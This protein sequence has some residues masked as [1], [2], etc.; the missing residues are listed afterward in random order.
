M[1]TIIQGIINHPS[2]TDLTKYLKFLCLEL[3]ACTLS[4]AQKIKDIPFDT[5]GNFKIELEEGDIA[6]QYLVKLVYKAGNKKELI[7]ASA[8]LFAG[9]THDLSFYFDPK[10]YEILL[11]YLQAQVQPHLG[12]L[13]IINL[14]E[15]QLQQLSSLSK[16]DITDLRALQLAMVWHEEWKV[17]V[18]KYLIIY[19]GKKDADKDYFQKAF[20]KLENLLDEFKTCQSILFALAK[21]GV[22]HWKQGISLS[23]NQLAEKIENVLAKKWVAIPISSQRV[24][25][26]GLGYLR[27]AIL[28][29]AAYDDLY[30]DAKLIYLSSY[31]AQTKSNLLNLS[32]EQNGLSNL[33]NSESNSNET[34][35]KELKKNAQDF[36]KKYSVKFDITDLKHVVDWDNRIRNFTP[37]LALIIP[38]LREN[39]WDKTTLLKY[40]QDHWAALIQ[41]VPSSIK[42]PTE[43]DDNKEPIRSYAYDLF[44]TLT[45]LFPT[46]KLVTQLNQSNL[47]NKDDFYRILRR[48]PNFDIQNQAVSR[49]FSIKANDRS[50]EKVSEKDYKNLQELQRTIKLADGVENLHIVEAL[51]KENLSSGMKISRFGKFE[52]TKVM[53]EYHFHEWEIRGVWCRA[54]AFYDTAKEFVRQYLQYD[55]VGS[56]MPAILQNNIN[57]QEALSGLPDMETLFGSLDKCSCKHC[58]SVYSPA[59][60]LTDMLQWLKSDISCQQSSISGFTELDRRRPDIKYIQL[61]CKNSNTVLPYIDLVNEVLLSHL[62]SIPDATLLKDLQTTWETDRLLMEPEHINHI[63]FNNAKAKLKNTLCP[64][65]LP[66]DINWTESRSYLNELGTSQAELIKIFSTNQ[67]ANHH[68][69]AWSKAFL[70]IDTTTYEF[71][72]QVSPTTNFWE[73]HFNKNN[74]EKNLDYFLRF[75]EIEKEDFQQIYETKFVSNKTTLLPLDVDFEGCDWDE[76][77]I[78]STWEDDDALVHRFVRFLRLRNL[79]GLTTEQLDRAIYTYN[80]TDIN[81]A[82]LINLTSIIDLSQKY[83]LNLDE[84]LVWFS[85][86][87]F[88][89]TS[90]FDWSTYY[91]NVY[92]KPSFSANRIA[93]FDPVFLNSSANTTTVKALSNEQK[94]W[95]NQSLG[96]QDGDIYLLNTY[97]Y[98]AGDPKLKTTE[99]QFYHI[100]ASLAKTLKLSIQELLASFKLF[101]SPFDGFPNAPAEV[102]YY[103]SQLNDT[104]NIGLSIEKL[105]DSYTGTAFFELQNDKATNVIFEEICKTVWENLASKISAIYTEHSK[106]YDTLANDFATLPTYVGNVPNLKDEL[107]QLLAHELEIEYKL[108]EDI[109]DYEDNKW[110]VSCL[111]NSIAKTDWISG[112]DIVF[113]PIFRYLYRIGLYTK[114]FE[115]GDNGLHALFDSYANNSYSLPVTDALFWLGNDFSTHNFFH[116]LWLKKLTA[117]KNT[118]SID[119]QSLF[120]QI[121]ALN[122]LTGIPSAAN[123]NIILDTCY[124][125]LSLL[126]NLEVT[127]QQFK[128][129]YLRAQCLAINPKDL[130]ETLTSTFKLLKFEN[131]IAIS[132]PTIWSWVWDDFKVSGNN[133]ITIGDEKAEIYTLL[134]SKYTD[135]QWPKIITPIHNKF[136]TKLRDALVAY[137]IHNKSYDNENDIYGHFL[138][139]P[140]ME[141]CMKTSRI[142]LAISGVQLLIHKALMGL[143]PEVCPNEDNKQE[144]KWRKNYRVWEANRKV[145]LYPENWIEPE[146]RLDKSEFFEELEDLLLQNEIN[147]EN[148]EKAMQRY[149]TN[150]NKVA[151][152]DIRGT[153]L[154]VDYN[155]DPDPG[156]LHVV[157]RTFSTPHE[158]YYRKRDSD[159]Y[160]TAWEKLEIDID[161]DHIIL[162]FHNRKLHL[163]WPM[164]IEKEHRKIKI[165]EDNAPYFEIRMCYSKLEFGKW[166]S[167]RILEGHVLAGHLAGKGCFN[168]LRYKLGQD[169]GS[170][171]IHNGSLVWGN[172]TFFDYAPVSMNKNKFFFWAE[173]RKDSGE[174]IIHIR[175][176]FDDRFDDYHDGYTELAY[177]DSFKISACDDRLEIIPPVIEEVIFDDLTNGKRFLARPYNTLPDGQLMIE[178]KDNEEDMYPVGGLYVKKEITHSHGSI[179]ILHKTN[180]IY[181]LTY[182]HQFK[183]ATFEMPFFLK[184][185]IHTLF[186]EKRIEQKCVKIPVFSNGATTWYT[187]EQ[188]NVLSKYYVQP[189]EHPYAC[190]MLGE[191]NQYGIKGLLSSRNPNNQ[192]RRQ[193]QHNNYFIHQYLPIL[194]Q[195]NYPFPIDEFDFSYFGAYQKY[196]WEIFFHAPSLI[197]KQLKNNGQF[198][199]AIKWLQFIFDPTNRD[200]ALNDKRFWM[201]KPFLKD[202]SENSIQNLMHLLGATGLNPEQ[203]KKREAL[204]AQIKRWKDNPFEPHKI[205]E[206]RHRAYMLWTVCEYIDVLIE[207]G[208]SLF[209]QDS[210]E[211][212]NEATNLYILAG[213]LLGNRPKTLNKP[214]NVIVDSFDTIKDG[215]DD[216]SNAVL[217][218]ENEIPAYSPIICC[219]ET[220]NERYQLPDLLFCIPDNPKLQELWNRAEDRLFKIRHCMNIEG[221]IRELPLFQPPIDPALLVRATAMG[222]DIG[223][224]LQEL[225]APT[226]HYRYTY[227]LQKANEFTGEVKALGG[228]LLS[229]LEKKDTEELN[230]LRQLHEQNILKATRNLKKMAIEEAKLGLAS[231]QHSKKLIEIRL[232]EYEGKDTLSD[233]ESRSMS[234]TK[235]AEL[236]MY[237]EQAQVLIAAAL[238]PIPNQYITAG[239]PPSVTIEPPTS[240]AKLEKISSLVGLSFGIVGSIYRNISSMQ[241][242]KAGYKRRQE[243]WDFQ[244]TTAKEEL[245]Q[246]EKSILS[247]EIRIAIAEKDFENHELQIEQSKEVFDFVKNKFTNLNLYSW[248]SGELMKLHYRAYKLAYEMAKQAQRAMNKELSIDLSIIDFGHWNSSRKGLLAGE[249]LSMQLKELDNAYIKND[250]RRFELSKDISLKLL[251][252][253]ALVHL[254]QHKYCKV[255]LEEE[256]LNLVFKS[257]NLTGMQIKSIGI[258]IPCVTGSQISTNVKLRVQN[259]EELITSSGV[260]DLGV[261][262]PNF[263]QA[264]YM[265]FEYLELKEDQAD[266]PK[267]FINLEVM[268]EGD[269]DKNPPE[270]D[271][272]TISDVVLH[273][274]YYAENNSKSTDT[275]GE[276]NVP[277]NQQHLVMSWKYDFPLE[278][279][280]IN[281]NIPIIDIKSFAENPLNKSKVPYKLRPLSFNLTDSFSYLIKDTND[282]MNLKSGTF[283]TDGS[284][285]D[286][287]NN[288]LSIEN[289][290]DIWLFYGI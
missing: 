111:A 131:E 280:K 102:F 80:S 174:L 190:L 208:D 209:R 5:K 91:N 177:E 138:L 260:N 279:Q 215:L 239:L 73:I 196:N 170:N 87:P 27:D 234:N 221:Q 164:F 45:N 205:A 203:E 269:D 152:L 157:G 66:Y 173:N 148:A 191:F 84:I 224:V 136:R 223:E 103:V 12:D 75:F 107:Y 201:I 261:F 172:D 237:A 287:D 141:A 7:N 100:H 281:S 106:A 17:V 214:A 33:L 59:A 252:P 68:T 195:I 284:L 44:S 115:L 137:Y 110:Y 249:K 145:F 248:M 272:T 117:I 210:I 36:K 206:M 49:H 207:W 76:F 124:T 240:G 37:L 149:L 246:V 276:V 242:T 62:D 144:W 243:D 125:D 50:P 263:N 253:G 265:P 23:I 32:L 275:I 6:V 105:A 134:K 98:G 19:E 29:Q 18:K 112:S 266:P 226:P 282:K 92:R 25:L 211:A 199:D 1:K 43:Y 139:D 151:R 257:R 273:V 47:P 54:Q 289:I 235:K 97:W 14:N 153:Y 147:D 20:H 166:S 140:E 57:T 286:K 156:A 58:Q 82:S 89:P 216:F 132:I 101:G 200:T 55:R 288:A 202:V 251:D 123:L 197:A 86:D 61:N 158:Y 95:I 127:N 181:H 72:K 113:T 175:R 176:D 231:T 233:L 99:L 51:F 179:K 122:I 119:Y 167:K 247:A 154:E 22:S 11:P 171:E 222:I 217:N 184:D 85:L 227:L 212:I 220:N 254:I 2:N 129:A 128:D 162:V 74:S 38:N 262:E 120:T 60:Y 130:I 258:S 283:D 161:G 114:G 268:L 42:H 24:L 104:R 194:Q 150:L 3:Y 219:K 77:E 277:S 31:D 259:G 271:I 94:E 270:Y 236:F 30:Y 267:K 21:E 9:K 13:Y 204:K 192:L 168:N 67:Y 180:S 96:L 229:A 278:W 198:A 116:I 160:W 90:S 64:I 40:T 48:N 93:F 155:G 189:H 39:E 225:N 28:L 182:P 218:I 88:A 83:V 126:D 79:S 228:A 159:K 135:E 183:H 56:F 213:E 250:K 133:P 52:F 53:Q 34:I 290:E 8:K 188:R 185:N 165:G 81:E 169:V 16:Q 108:F 274:R 4:A 78:S 256:L 70:G 255:K 118:F 285:L 146:L 245:K 69:V 35:I 232:A 187:T 121:E 46:E 26:D 71:L 65:N 63:S 238:T 142:K 230:L 10:K 241:L 264:R 186:F 109:L 244:I 178:G 41:A 163:Y 193:A 15:E 143:E